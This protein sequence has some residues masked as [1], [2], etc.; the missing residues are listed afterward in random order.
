MKRE[1]WTLKIPPAIDRYT[2]DKIP[3]SLRSQSEN[4]KKIANVNGTG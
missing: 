3:L 1:K 2:I 4:V